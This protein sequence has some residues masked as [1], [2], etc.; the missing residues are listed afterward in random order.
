MSASRSKNE[1]GE[2]SELLRQFKPMKGGIDSTRPICQGRENLYGNMQW[3]PVCGHV[4]QKHNMN[5]SQ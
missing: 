2:K 4:T 5:Q 3:A 1:F